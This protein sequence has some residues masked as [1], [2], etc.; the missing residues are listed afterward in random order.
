MPPSEGHATQPWSSDGVCSF[1]S[2]LGFLGGEWVSLGN[3]ERKVEWKRGWLNRTQLPLS[4]PFC[5]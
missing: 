1:F 5:C 2:L 4:Y 3:A